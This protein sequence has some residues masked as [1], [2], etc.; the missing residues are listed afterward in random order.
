[1]TS[2]VEQLINDQIHILQDL[3]RV[4][5]NPDGLRLMRQIVKAAESAQPDSRNDREPDSDEDDEQNG[6]API[7]ALT[8]AVLETLKTFGKSQ[9]TVHDVVERMQ[10]TG[11]KFAAKNPRVAV[12]SILQKLVEN[13]QLRIVRHGTGGRPHAYENVA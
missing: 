6:Q 11:F 4:A 7:T 3:K 10:S 9:F 5:S 12:S 2:I 8:P 13:G 1:M